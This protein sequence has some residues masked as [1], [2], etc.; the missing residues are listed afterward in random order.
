MLFWR[1]KPLDQILETA[2]KKSL[3][4]QLGAFQLTMLGIG[5][6]IAS[7]NMKYANLP[8]PVTTIVVDVPRTNSS[9]GMGS[10]TLT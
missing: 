8:A 2:A 4:R 3:V 7:T 6:I 9:L 1:V 10:S 5:A